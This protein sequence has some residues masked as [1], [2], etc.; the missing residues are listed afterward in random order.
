MPAPCTAG[1][2]ADVAHAWR[3]GQDALAAGIPGAEHVT[4]P[5]TSHYVQNQRLAVVVAVREVVTRAASAR[6]TAS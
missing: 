6:P 5:G 1:E 3:D 2:R 4:V